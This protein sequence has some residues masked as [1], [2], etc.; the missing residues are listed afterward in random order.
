MSAAFHLGA[1]LPSKRDTL[2]VPWTQLFLA[3][4]AE[5]LMES[6]P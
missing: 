4:T 2:G 1:E 5:L 6:D 3:D